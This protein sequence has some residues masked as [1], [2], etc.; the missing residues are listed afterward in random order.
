MSHR[1]C[2]DDEI[3][4]AGLAWQQAFAAVDY[5]KTL[6]YIDRKSIVLETA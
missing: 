2:G 3:C 6:E 1:T 5:S 4:V